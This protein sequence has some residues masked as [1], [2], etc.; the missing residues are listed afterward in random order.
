ASGASRPWG[1]TEFVVQF[2][3]CMLFFGLIGA[4]VSCWFPVAL[5]LFFF[6]TGDRFLGWV[7]GKLGIR[8]VSDT[9]GAEFVKAFVFFFGLWVCLGSWKESAPAWLL[10]WIP[11]NASWALIGGTALFC[12]VLQLI[13]AAIVRKLLPRIGIEIAP[14]RQGW[15]IIAVLG[16]LVMLTLLVATSMAADWPG[17]R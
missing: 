14:E 2:I 13:S 1:G 10:P 8:L 12:A 4:W 16:V 6:F 15:A 11:L 3:F 7:L 17:D 9:L 5:G